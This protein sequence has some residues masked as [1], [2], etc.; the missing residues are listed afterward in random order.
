MVLVS[1][2]VVDLVATLGDQYRDYRSV[3]SMLVPLPRRHTT[4]A[5]RQ[6]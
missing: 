1:R 5:L 3:T 6:S 2:I 4:E